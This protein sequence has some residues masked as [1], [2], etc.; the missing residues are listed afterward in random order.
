MK[1][2]F[3]WNRKRRDNVI[4]FCQCFKWLYFP[5]WYIQRYATMQVIINNK[6]QSGEW[7]LDKAKTTSFV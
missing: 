5:F 3:F 4:R 1:K 7:D 6:L 2:R